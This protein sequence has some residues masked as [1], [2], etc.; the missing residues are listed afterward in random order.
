ML[1]KNRVCFVYYLFF[2][3]SYA[4]VGVGDVKVEPGLGQTR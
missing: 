4:V 1:V 3:F 2:N